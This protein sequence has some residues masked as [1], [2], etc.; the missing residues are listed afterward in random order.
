MMFAAQQTQEKCREQNLDLSMVFIDLTK[1]FDSI[2]RKGI[3]KI[4]LKVG[5]PPRVVNIIRSFHDGMMA[6]V[7]DNGAES[8][9]FAVSNGT[10]QGCGMT[11]LLF[12]IVFS[13]MLHDVFKDCDKGVLIRFRKDGGIFNLQRL[14]VDFHCRVF[15]YAC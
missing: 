11:P 13:A 8:D 14:K 1:A 3:C 9:S 2:N 7:S 6:R 10:K 12:G 15:V 4:L 5:C